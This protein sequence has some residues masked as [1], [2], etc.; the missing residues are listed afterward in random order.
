MKEPKDWMDWRVWDVV[1]ICSPIDYGVQN[2]THDEIVESILGDLLLLH[3]DEWKYGIPW[4]ELFRFIQTEKQ[5]N[6][7]LDALC[8]Q[9]VQEL[10]IE[11][12]EYPQIIRLRPDR[13]SLQKAMDIAKSWYGG[14]EIPEW[15]Q[16][17]IVSLSE[18]GEAIVDIIGADRA[19]NYFV[20]LYIQKQGGE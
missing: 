17:Q 13:D 10:V 5:T 20:D 18:R 11:Y 15:A 12:K 2:M 14:F 9:K 8:D 19:A 4:Y 3:F 1:E 6:R 16:G 7:V